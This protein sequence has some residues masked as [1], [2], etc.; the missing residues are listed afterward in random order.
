MD[1]RGGRGPHRLL[2]PFST[3]NKCLWRE[4]MSLRAPWRVSSPGFYSGPHLAAHSLNLEEYPA[5]FLTTHDPNGP[6][7]SRRALRS[8]VTERRASG[9]SLAP[10]PLPHCLRLRCRHLC[11]CLGPGSAPPPSPPSFLSAARPA[12]MA[13]V[14]DTKLYDILGVPPGASEN[15]LKKVLGRGPAG[16]GVRGAGLRD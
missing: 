8:D 3:P 16:Q 14:A 9:Q 7:R 10:P 13:N 15:E 11:R 2:H 6:L 4:L 5:C 1:R 12:A